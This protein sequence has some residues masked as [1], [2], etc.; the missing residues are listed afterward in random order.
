MVCAALGSGQQTILLRKGGID[1]G[2]EGF[3][4]SHSEFWLLPTRF[5]Q[6]P[7]QLVCDARPLWEQTQRNQPA[8]GQFLVDLFAVVHSVFEVRDEAALDRL[9]GMHILSA[10]TLHQR[11]HYRRPGLFV[12]TVR[13]YRMPAAYHVVDSPYIAGCKSW[14][15]LPEQFLT[16][17]T[18]PVLDDATFA[19]RARQIEDRFS[20]VA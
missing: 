10:E 15:E 8:S 17:G 16:A 13:T 11:Y 4:V 12:L 19:Q 1:E 5:H 14:V 9:S 2:R 20:G 3:R 18:A 7:E 6:S